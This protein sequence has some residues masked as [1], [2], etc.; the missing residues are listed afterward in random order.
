MS[1]RM[2]AQLL[3]FLENG[4]IQRVGLERGNRQ[5]MRA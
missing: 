5:S 4:E 1:L 2:Q 3:R